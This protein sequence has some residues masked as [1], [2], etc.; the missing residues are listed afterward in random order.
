MRK[1]LTPEQLA[2][3]AKQYMDSCSACNGRRILESGHQC[4]CVQK[5]DDA[6]RQVEANIPVNFRDKAFDF[7]DNEFKATNP[8]GFGRIVKYAQKLPE[9]LQK[10]VSLYINGPEGSGKSF[11]GVNIL[12][13]AIKSKFSAYFMLSE[14]LLHLAYDAQINSELRDQ[15][16]Q[17]M[18]ECDFLL[19]DEIS[20]M[21]MKHNASPVVAL[22]NGFFK[23][24]FYAN[25]PIIFTSTKLKDDLDKG[26]RHFVSIFDE[27]LID[28][29][30]EANHKPKLR[31]SMTKEFLNDN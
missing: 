27:R 9:A 3:L 26:L 16:E 19:I 28:V 10:G 25:K 12:K 24:R 5:F 18:R 6:V 1:N 20:G 11:L 14:T 17:M 31:S 8:D 22:L 15:M 7:V 30:I 4:V 23:A 29:Y 2:I 21:Y 13:R